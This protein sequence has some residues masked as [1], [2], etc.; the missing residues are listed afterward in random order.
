[1]TEKKLYQGEGCGCFV[2]PLPQLAVL[3]VVVALVL[4]QA[5]KETLVAL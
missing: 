4:H 3:C 1:M 5:L 2:S